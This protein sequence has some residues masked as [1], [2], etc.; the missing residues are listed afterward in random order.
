MNYNSVSHSVNDWRNNNKDIITNDWD[1]DK[2]N[3]VERFRQ[4][5]NMEASRKKYN[6]N[7]PKQQIGRTEYI[8]KT[9]NKFYFL[10]S[11]ITKETV[12]QRVINTNSI[13]GNLPEPAKRPTVNI[14]THS[15]TTVQEPTYGN[16]Q[17]TNDLNRERNVNTNMP[18]R[19]ENSNQMRN[20]E[21]YNQNKWKQPQQVQP[22]QQPQV[23][24]RQQPQVQ[25]RQSTPSSP[26]RQPENRQIQQPQ[27]V[28]Q[29][30]PAPSNINRK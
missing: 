5:G 15:R 24:P 1:F 26:V 7:N 2:T 28:R 22:R 27:P 17:P 14:P 3:R 8:Q 21:Q 29:N 20:A 6:I 25:P 16:P 30:N 12:N 19:S 13:Q 23:Q 18:V 10:N 4:Y 9:P 11:D